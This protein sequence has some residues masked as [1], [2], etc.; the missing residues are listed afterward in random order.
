MVEGYTIV[1]AL[2]FCI[3]YMHEY[4][5]TTRRVWDDKENS[6]MYDEMLEGG[7]RVRRLPPGL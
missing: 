7:E 4:I 6:L 5:V 2:E 1:E 3:D